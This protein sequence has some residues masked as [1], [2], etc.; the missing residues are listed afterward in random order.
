MICPP[1]SN[2]LPSSPLPCP[3]KVMFNLDSRGLVRPSIEGSLNPGGIFVFSGPPPIAA[4]PRPD[5]LAPLQPE[6]AEAATDAETP[7]DDLVPGDL[8]ADDPDAPIADPALAGFKPRQRPADLQERFERATQNG[9]TTDELAAIRPLQRPADAAAASV[10]AR[11][12]AI[13]AALAEAAAEEA[14]REQ[15]EAQDAEALAARQAEEAAQEENTGTKLAVASSRRPGTRPRNF[16]R[17]VARAN[18]A[19][20]T[21]NN[22]AAASAARAAGPAVSRSSRARPTGPVSATV[23]RAATDNNALALGKVALVGVFG[24]SS[25]RRALVRM[26]NG[27]FKKVSV[28]DRVDGGRVAAIGEG[29]LKY[30]KGSRTLTL[31]MPKG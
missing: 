12:E 25:N 24:T 5:G 22:A 15:Q 10:R 3:P 30:T 4:V 6:D 28:G 11:E 1:P 19:N 2:P 18:R 21:Q 29:Q 9:R 23:A 26:P 13:A 8:A 20:R 16:D 7:A 14:L 31:Q 27:R 17:V